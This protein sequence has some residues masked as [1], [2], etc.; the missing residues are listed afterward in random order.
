MRTTRSTGG[1]GRTRRSTRPARRDVPVLLSVGYASCHWCHVMA[2]ESFTDPQTAAYLN[3]RFVRIKV[4]REERPGRRRGVHDRDAG[5]DR[6]RRLAD[7]GVPHAPTAR[8]SSPGPT[9]RR[10]RRAA[11]RRSGRCSPRCPRPGWTT[12]R[13]HSAPP[14]GSAPPWRDMTAALPAGSLDAR[15]AGPSGRDGARPGRPGRRRIRRRTQV[16]AG[17]GLRIPAATPRADRVRGRPRR[18]HLTCEKMS[19]GGML[20]QL[21]GGF[22]RY[23]STSIWHVPHFEKMLEDN[24]LLLGVYSH[25]ARL[26]GSVRSREIALADR[27]RFRASTTCV[28]MT[29]C[30]PPRWTPRRRRRRA[31]RICGRRR[32]SGGCSGPSAARALDL[33]GMH[34]GPGDQVISWA[35]RSSGLEPADD[36]A[37]AW[38]AET[39]PMRA[40]LLAVRDQRPQPGRD[41]IVVLR[42]NAL[43][44]AALAE[45]GGLFDRPDWIAAA[46]A[47]R[48]GV[49]PAP[50]RR[51]MAA[52]LTARAGRPG[53]GHAGRPRRPGAGRMS[54]CSRRRA[55]RR[56]VSRPL[57][58]SPTRDPRS[59]PGRRGSTTPSPASRSSAP[60]TRPTVRPRPALRRW[61]TRC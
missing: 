34:D 21:G 37:R 31:S 5:A 23:A 59:P 40:S 47:A 27:R 61:P 1:N 54:R 50:G 51:R 46:A 19:A 3:E 8:R 35:P 32:R 28:P 41:E 56:G 2:R 6:G 58:W 48:P 18:G 36:L 55:S 39:A 60:A 17:D 22:A 12:G 44:I 49:R 20:D 43:M 29:G 30:S 38:T 45:S 10:S 52:Q 14:A 24:A 15:R 7:D 25:H 11:I 53:S 42:S 9:S 26:T 4:D 16:P 57:P 13:G 33:F